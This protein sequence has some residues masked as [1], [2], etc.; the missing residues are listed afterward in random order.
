MSSERGSSSLM[1]AVAEQER[2]SVNCPIVYMSNL[3]QKSRFGC[4]DCDWDS[5]MTVLRRPIEKLH[6]S[7]S[8]KPLPEALLKTGDIAD[9]LTDLA[10][11]ILPFLKAEELMNVFRKMGRAE[12]CCV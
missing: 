5:G 8:V 7:K 3:M 9:V 10:D 11:C 6:T 2:T 4:R 12:F 1:L